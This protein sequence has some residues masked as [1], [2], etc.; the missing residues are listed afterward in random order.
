[1]QG[2]RKPF[3]KEEA[4]VHACLPGQYYELKVFGHWVRAQL[5]HLTDFFMETLLLLVYFAYKLI[6]F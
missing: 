1:M 4:V 2:D 6:L 5:H 3:S